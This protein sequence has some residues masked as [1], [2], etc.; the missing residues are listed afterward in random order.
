MRNQGRAESRALSLRP[1][2]RD[3]AW[4][5]ASRKLLGGRANGDVVL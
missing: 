5:V 3:R 4:S 2:A 1:A